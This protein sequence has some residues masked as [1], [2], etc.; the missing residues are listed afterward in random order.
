MLDGEVEAEIGGDLLPSTGLVGYVRLTTF[1]MRKARDLS[2]RPPWPRF[3]SGAIPLAD[4]MDAGRIHELNALA[5]N[6]MGVSQ[7]NLYISATAEGNDAWVPHTL[8]VRCGTNYFGFKD[9]VAP[10]IGRM[11][12]LALG[13]GTKTKP[14]KPLEVAMLSVVVEGIGPRY[15]GYR[16]KP[17]TRGTNQGEV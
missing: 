12:Q 2:W 7:A 5:R 10:V 13:F 6:E 14:Q 4:G 17:V 9:R 15:Q 11:A 16:A 8:D 3:V 1:G